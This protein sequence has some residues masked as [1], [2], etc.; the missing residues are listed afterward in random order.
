VKDILGVA[1]LVALQAI[2]YRKLY[3]EQDQSMGDWV[4]Q[5]LRS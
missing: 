1:A 5:A 3:P 4:P 2:E